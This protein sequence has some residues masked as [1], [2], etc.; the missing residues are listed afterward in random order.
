MELDTTLAPVW[1]PSATPKPDCLVV[2]LHAHVAIPAAAD[3]AGRHLDPTRDPR[4]KHANAAS[5]EYNTF[6]RSRIEQKFT[7]S[8]VRLADMD[9]MGVDVQVLSIGPPHYFYWADPDLGL[10]IARLQNDGIAEMAA[11]DPQR[12]IGMG[13]LPLQAPAQAM[14]ELRRLA[15]DLGLRGV[16]IDTNVAGKD[17][18]HADFE[19]FWDEIERRGLLVILHPYGFDEAARFNDYY[20]TNVLGLPLDSTVALSRLILGGVLERHPDLRLMV[21]H[22][23]GYLPY[24]IARTDHAYRHRP[25]LRRNITRAPS[26]YLRLVH[27]DITTHSSEA[28]A[29][30]VSRYGPERVVL[31]TDYP[32]DMGVTDPVTL[33]V[34]AGLSPDQARLVFGGNAARLLGLQT[35]ATER[36]TS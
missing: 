1:G 6:L 7:D 8:A 16:Q 32:Y 2:D 28:V 3:L 19:P 34:E 23:G 17:L 20:L 22:G 21:V 5:T 18:D 9:A 11:G 33:V 14:T 27:F 36:P 24:Y 35:S 15:D 12:F 26:E 30:L 31:G 29:Y 25:E 13:T 4:L 10:Q